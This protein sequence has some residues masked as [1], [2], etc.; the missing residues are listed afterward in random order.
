[1]TA[2]LSC[3]TAI[4]RKD[5]HE[6]RF[7]QTRHHRPDPRLLGDPTVVGALDHPLRERRL[8]RS[9]SRL[10]RFRGRGRGAQRRPV[11]DR[12]SDRAA[13]HRAP[14]VGRRWARLAADP[15]R[16]LRRWRVR[17]DPARPRLR[18]RGRRHQLGPDGGREAG[19]AV[20]G[21]GDVPGV[22]EPRQPPQGRRVHARAMA[23]RVHEHVQRGGVAGAVRAL[24]HPGVGQHLL[25][26]R[27]GEHPPR[28]RRQLGQ[29]RERRPGAAAVHRRAA[30][31]I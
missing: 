7:P 16:A 28:P 2:L 21:P 31:T 3:E 29:L 9:R 17:A 19:A 27:A 15:D 5:N 13:D 30:R 10:S 8:P 18:R 25:G 6:H 23:L 1:M 14:R 20:A 12:G 11:A 24:P 22:E 4:A 26:Q